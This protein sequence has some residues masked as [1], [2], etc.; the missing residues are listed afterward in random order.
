LQAFD[1][2]VF[3]SHSPVRGDGREIEVAA[4]RI[5]VAVDEHHRDLGGFR[6]LQHRIP[7]RRHHGR[8]QDRVHTL[9][10]EGPDRLDLILLLLLGVRDLEVDA[11]LLGLV[12]GDGGLGRTPARFRANLREPDRH[13]GRRDRC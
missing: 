6:L 1:P 7:A 11:A 12:A 2:T 3:F 8:Q 4:R 9:R 13:L 10:H 5:D